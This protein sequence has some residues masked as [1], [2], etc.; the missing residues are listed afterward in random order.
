M[1]KFVFVLS[2]TTMF[3]CSTFAYSAGDVN[4]KVVS[5]RVDKSGKGYIVFEQNLT[6]EPALC[7]NGYPNV[8]AFDVNTPGG[9]AIM[10]VG[11]TAQASGQRIRARGTG[12]CGIY[13]TIE[14]WNWGY[15]T[16]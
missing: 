9:Q 14:S 4:A 6:L 1:I 2:L 15:V 3:F 7:I 16:K 11:L 8:L 10:S 13:S 5:V 12:D